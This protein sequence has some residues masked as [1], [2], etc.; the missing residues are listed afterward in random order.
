MSPF[1]VTDTS[2]F[3]PPLDSTYTR[4]AAIFRC[5]FGA[6]YPDPKFLAN[7]NA[8]H[9]LWSNRRLQG[10]AVLYTVFLAA[11]SVQS[12]YQAL[13]KLVGPTVP[14]WL[15]GIMIDVEAWPG[16]SYAIRGNHSAAVNQLA[17]MHAHRMGSFK[18]VKAYANV[19]DHRALYPGRDARVDAIV[20]AYRSTSPLDQVP[21]AVG[22]QYTDGEDR[23]P[24]PAGYPRS[25]TPFGRCDH[26]VFPG[27]KNAAQFRALWGRPPQGVT[28]VPAKPVVVA[29]KPVNGYTV[30]AKS[31]SGHT[32][33]RLWDDG[34]VTVR[35][36]NQHYSTL[37]GA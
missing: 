30:A 36:N 34:S 37:K 15:T 6:D 7:A 10:G 17:G 29:P 18:S 9:K 3:Q 33:L 23:Y 26:N 32:E 21:R 24:V 25:S 22:W 5:C 13:W 16:T 35:R 2:T 4:P 27:V 14:D 1:I 31:P 11:Q 20:A 8:A 19:G 12:Q 28:P